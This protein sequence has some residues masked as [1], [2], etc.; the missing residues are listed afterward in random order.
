MR[1]VHRQLCRINNSHK[2]F[3]DKTK[4]CKVITLKFECQQVCLTL[5]NVK[6]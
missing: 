2:H 5:L 1:E 3:N 4:T 6:G